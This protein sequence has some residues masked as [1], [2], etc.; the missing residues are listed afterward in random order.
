[1]TLFTI[2]NVSN[3]DHNRY[4]E[5]FSDSQFFNNLNLPIKVQNPTGLISKL[6][7]FETEKIFLHGETPVFYIGFLKAASE[8]TINTMVI[9][10]EYLNDEDLYVFIKDEILEKKTIFGLGYEFSY[11]TSDND[12]NNAFLEK[13]GF[14]PFKRYRVMNVLL[15]QPSHLSKSINSK[16]EFTFKEVRDLQEIRDRV[17][18]QNSAF[19]NNNRIPLNEDDIRTEMLNSTYVHEL[20]LLMYDSGSPVGYGQII[21]TGKMNYLVNFGILR[22][23]QGKGYSSILMEELLSRTSVSGKHSVFLE[24]FEKNERAVKLYE[25][26]GFKT[27]YR[28]TLWHYGTED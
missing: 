10:K 25:K 26:H 21:K 14:K 6:A 16:S 1:M 13:L 23:M 15:D 4:K 20:S 19:N 27:M 12:L 5:F 2:K 3:E 8:I 18:V 17:L 7:G 22:E 9:N 11:M 28:K 24:V